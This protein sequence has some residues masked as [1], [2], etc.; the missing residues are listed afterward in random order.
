MNARAALL[1][2]ADSQLLFRPERLPQ[3]AKHFAG[4]VVQAAYVGASNGNQPAFYELACAALETLLG[5]PV[6]CTFVRTAGDLPEQ[7]VNLLVLAGGS[8]SLGWAFL[9]QPALRSWLDGILNDPQALAIGVSAGAI[10]LA[11]GCDPEQCDPEQPGP[12]AQS[13]LDA[14]PHF[15]AVHEE[16]Q[17]W[18]SRQVWQAGGCAG[19]FVAIP[20][21]G[22]LWCQ[23]ETRQAMG[24][25]S[26]VS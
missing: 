14:F 23:G 8:V 10:H 25:L 11:R 9:Q 3:V 2:L 1:L 5:Q 20:L 16:Q 18:P 24:T 15:I 4:R 19:E 26:A 6:P 7:P 12:L 13:Y 22:G 21:G 17:H